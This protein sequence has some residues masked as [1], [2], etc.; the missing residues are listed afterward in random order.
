MVLVSSLLAYLAGGRPTPPAVPLCPCGTPADDRDGAPIC[1]ACL[2][3][4]ADLAAHPAKFEDQ[5]VTGAVDEHGDVVR[6]G[7]MPVDAHMHVTQAGL[8][9]HAR[10]LVVWE[11]TADWP[12]DDRTLED[13]LETRAL[14]RLWGAA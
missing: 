7:T 5:V 11:W 12:T 4:R 6:L 9:I 3:R 13:I 8:L 14:E 2:I 1:G 10:S